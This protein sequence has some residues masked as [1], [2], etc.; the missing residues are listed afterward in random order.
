MM[1]RC[2]SKCASRR[3]THA[4]EFRIPIERGL[5]MRTRAIFVTMLAV[6]MGAA[7][8]A[9]AQVAPPTPPTAPTPPTPPAA[10]TPRPAPVVLPRI[11]VDLSALDQARLASLDALNVTLPDVQVITREALDRARIAREDMRRDYNFDFNFDLQN[12]LQLMRGSE[13]GGY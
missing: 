7:S 6:M 13:S 10:P 8:V 1:M 5:T 9:A 3:T 2:C 12:D 4:N 11:D